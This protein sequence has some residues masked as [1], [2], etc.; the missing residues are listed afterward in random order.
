[1]SR[2]PKYA[3][4]ADGNQ[5]EIKN[6]LEKAGC[7]VQIIGSPVDLLVGYRVRNFLIECKTNETRYG[8]EDTSTPAQRKFF[9]N[10][11]GQVR[12]VWSAE[13]AIQ[14]V[15]H[16]YE[17]PPGI[18]DCCVCNGPF[19]PD[20]EGGRIGTIGILTVAFCPTCFTGVMDFAEQEMEHYD[21]DYLKELCDGWQ[22]KETD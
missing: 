10:W 13:E 22:D 16:G 7:S 4:A 11:K 5:K 9:K 17:N 18:H 2:R 1:M 14:L 20:Q 6:A 12:K 19:S 15:R 8:K 21:E 3:Q